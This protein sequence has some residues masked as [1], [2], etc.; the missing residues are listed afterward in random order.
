MMKP[1]FVGAA[2]WVATSVEEQKFGLFRADADGE[3]QALTRGL[4]D[5][6]AVGHRMTDDCRGLASGREL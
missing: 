6:V 3:W 4:P 5:K 2:P 1:V